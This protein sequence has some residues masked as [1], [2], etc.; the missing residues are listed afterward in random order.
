MNKIKVL[1][2]LI[3]LPLLLLQGCG[4][5][6]TQTVDFSG[7]EKTYLV[8]SYPFNQQENVSNKS[9]VLLSFSH[10]IEDVDMQSH[11]QLLDKNDVVVAGLLTQQEDNPETLVFVPSAP[12]NAGSRY[13]IDYAGLTSALGEVADVKPI[14]FNTQSDRDNEA[15]LAGS[16]PGSPVVL[17]AF[18]VVSAFPSDDLPFMDFSSIRLNF[19]HQIDIDSLAL[20]QGFS[21]KKQ[22]SDTSVPGQLLVKGRSLTFDPNQ[23]L[24]PGVSYILSLSEQIKSLS[25]L[26]LSPIEYQQKVFLPQS[27]LPRTT[28]VQKITDSNGAKIKSPL[29]GEPIN[30]VP[31]KSIL[32]GEDD[33][34]FV[35]GDL[36]AE[37]AFIPNYPTAS[38]LVIRKGSV[39]KGSS[40]DVKIGGQIPAGFSTETINM[41]MVSDGHGYLID[42]T[43]TTDRNAPKQV[44]LL[45]DI[46]MTADG[47]QANGA[48]SQDILHLEL[49]GW[50]KTQN[51]V[52]V[53]DAIGQVAPR[54]LGLEDASGTVSFHL[55]AYADQNNAP[56][57][58]VDDIAPVL[59]SWVPGDNEAYMNLSEP[60][61][62]TFSE[63]LDRDSLKN[64][65][66]L[67]INGQS[68][69]IDIRQDG[70]VLIIQPDAA[71]LAG[72]DYQLTLSEVISDITGN[73]ITPLDLRFTTPEINTGA[74][75]A[76]LIESAYPGYNCLMRDTNIAAGIAGRCVD[77]LGGDDIFSMFE[78]PEN[79][80]VEVTFNQLMNT[81]TMLLGL[82]CDEGSVRFEEVDDS[83]SCIK[84]VPG[85]LKRRADRLSF[86]PSQQWQHGINYRYKLV[87]SKNGSCDD[88]SVIC[89][90]LNLPLNTNPLKLTSENR[91]EGDA[92]FSIVFSA[93]PA[94]SRYVL[95]PLA[96]IPTADSNKNF[97]YDGS[98][99]QQ[100]KN[101]AKLTIKGTD[102]LVK[103]ATMGCEPGT[104]PCGDRE[105]IY[106]TGLLP[107]DVGRWDAQNDRVEVKIYPQ[108]LMAT[109]AEMWAELNLFITTTWQEEPTGPQI[110][111]VRYDKDNQGKMI[112][113]KGYITEN[114]S[115]QAIFTTTLNVYLDAPELKPISL[116]ETNLHSL[117]L[118]M[119]LT[120]PVTFLEDGRME[121]QLTNSEAVAIDVE[122]G[123]NTAEVNLA[124]E[125]GDL[126]LNLVSRLIK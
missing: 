48:L 67:S 5:E 35:Q 46:A 102:G 27:S 125:V 3:F 93:I 116:L 92:T 25:G 30:S 18:Q 106:I 29:S 24:D 77:G 47:A 114:A 22:D 44:R 71:L 2:T 73:T 4:E 17:P 28:L 12:L 56:D 63:P 31:I 124:I 16:E 40:I 39:M 43:S 59:Q 41:T 118:T 126:S 26:A 21:F 83:G 6:E 87:S 53:I 51:N 82:N 14:S 34:T 109:S 20:D 85:V 50:A 108:A 7:W 84:T 99:S 38:P 64:T 75:A 58:T 110:M 23:D 19:S 88:G 72:T 78:L 13:R 55:E 91:Q 33:R 119:H 90:Q 76:A 66:D 81:D 8:Y 117:P 61:L 120:G 115:G 103:N 65:I 122:I 107:T 45:L 10:P 74:K 95:N 15:P 69:G 94:E 68:Q 80:D 101:S 60:L 113:P 1:I 86:T 100:E 98:E 104:G 37:L 79:R 9:S 89:S 32:L 121:V 52:M 70:S 54:I 42:N 105:F 97:V 62:L 49:F 111:R 96:K 36:H 11:V 57:L 123:G 112:P